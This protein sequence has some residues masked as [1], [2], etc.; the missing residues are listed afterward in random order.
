MLACMQSACLARTQLEQCVLSF[1]CHTSID[2]MLSRTCSLTTDTPFLYMS[3]AHAVIQQFLG[4]AEQC[5]VRMMRKYISKQLQCSR[6]ALELMILASQPPLHAAYCKPIKTVRGLDEY[7]LD[8][9][10][11]LGEIR[12]RMWPAALS[13]RVVLY[14]R[15]RGDSTAAAATA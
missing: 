10:T 3:A 15:S 2:V 6:D 11:T 9:S 14:Y 7:I 1:R 5:T 4:T 13:D 8:S 12:A